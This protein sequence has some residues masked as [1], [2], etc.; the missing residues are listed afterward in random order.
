MAIAKRKLL[1][2]PPDEAERKILEARD[3]EIARIKAETEEQLRVVRDNRKKA[4][5]A[6]KREERKQNQSRAFCVGEFLLRNGLEDKT[7][8]AIIQTDAFDKFMR[9]IRYAG[10]RKLFGLPE[11]ADTPRA[12][13]RRKKAA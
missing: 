7:L 10:R 11:L 13:G 1:T 2:L 9:G 4:T 12:G 5:I 3:A 6:E 8:Q